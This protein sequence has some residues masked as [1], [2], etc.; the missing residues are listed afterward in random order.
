MQFLIAKIALVLWPLISA[1]TV[2][3]QRPAVAGGLLLVGAILFLPTRVVFDFPA[4]PPLGREE[5]ASLSLL[6]LAC[7]RYP[8]RFFSSRPGLGVESL[9]FVV[10]A[11]GIGTA[12]T[13][14]DPLAY[15]PRNLPPVEAYDAVSDSVRDIVRYFVPF[16]V[17]RVLF[18]SSRD[19]RDLLTIIAAAG[20]VYSLFIFVELRLS[21]QL[22][23]WI[24]GFF[25]HSFHQS[26]RGDSYR[27]MVF[28]PNGL[29]VAQFML[30]ST[31]SAGALSAARLNRF[32]FSGQVVT[33]YLAGVLVLCKS[34]ASIAFGMLG[35][36]VIALLS[37]RTRI[38]IAAGLVSLFLAYPVLRGYDLFPTEK[39]VAAASVLSA[40]RAHSLDYRFTN[41]ELLLEKAQER[42]LFG[43]GGFGRSRI[44]DERRGGLVTI[45]DGFWIIQLGQRGI[46]GMLSIFGFIA[47]PVLLTYRRFDRIHSR[48]DR[49]LM[50]SLALIVSLLAIDL[51]PNGLFTYLPLV[52]S[53]ALLGLVEGIPQEQIRAAR[54]RKRAASAAPPTGSEDGAILAGATPEPE[55]LTAPADRGASLA[56][57]RRIRH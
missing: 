21:P 26:V 50:A 1:I 9:I 24:Y 11:G 42:I 56:S 36:P 45:V 54:A 20:L 57:A 52:L 46:L 4:A 28:M 47:L 18:R 3:A 55:P 51:L 15:G 22:N 7:I 13:N 40:E 5:I 34:Y 35:V 10:I 25:P 37:A 16:M 38:A 6:V 31:L 32:G 49:S 39:L 8:R 44:Y 17:A 41:E 12:L 27:P 48:R 30:L 33:T 19:L 53:G 23:R 43:W 29:A 2:S 14:S